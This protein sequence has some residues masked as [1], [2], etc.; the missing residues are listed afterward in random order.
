SALLFALFHM[1]FYQMPGAFLAGLL[2]AW[3]VVKT[4]SLWPSLFGHALMNGLPII[5][6]RVFNLKIPG[7]T[8]QL[9]GRILF[10]PLWLDGVGLA[11]MAF[12]GWL[13]WPRL[14]EKLIVSTEL[15]REGPAPVDPVVNLEEQREIPGE[16]LAE[17]SEGA[18]LET[19][20]VR[21]GGLGLASLIIGIVSILALAGSLFLAVALLNHYDQ[22]LAAVMGLA[23][24]MGLLASLIGL[25]LGIAGVIKKQRLTAAW[26]GIFLNGFYVLAGILII[27]LGVSNYQK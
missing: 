15:L 16:T 3:L 23:I 22:S 25:G 21:P 7:L 13:L 12:G 20:P 14:K 26:I 11:L 5:A 27:I 24:L 4:G 17:V 8:Y 1:N 10:Q 9:E 6:E 2:F 19:S 18:H